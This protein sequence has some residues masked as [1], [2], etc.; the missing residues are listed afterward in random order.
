MLANIIGWIF[1]ILGIL[2]I[3]KPEILRNKLQKK[4]IKKLKKY[5]FYLALIISLGLLVASFKMSGIGAKIIAILG[6]IGIFKAI[7][8]LKAKAADKML[9]WSAKQP[10][11]LFRFGGAIYII[12]GIAILRFS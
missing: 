12:I 1:V 8:L 11:N 9:E 3:V 2:F 7:F 4:G 10:L 6:I 5:L